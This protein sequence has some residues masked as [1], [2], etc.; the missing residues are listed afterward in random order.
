MVS[1]ECH[2]NKG[3]KVE[4][5]YVLNVKPL[6]WKISRGLV[7]YLP[8]E[9]LPLTRLFFCF[10]LETGKGKCMKSLK[11]FLMRELRCSGVLHQGLRAGLTEASLFGAYKECSVRLSGVDDGHE[12]MSRQCNKPVR[13]PHLRRQTEQVHPEIQAKRSCD[14]KVWT[15]FLNQ[16]LKWF[17]SLEVV[18]V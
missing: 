13:R 16:L 15:Q 5:Q 3:R 8:S 9:V 4:F 7:I 18:K 17:W 14:F 10:F 12:M 1:Q 6:F 2:P 11:L